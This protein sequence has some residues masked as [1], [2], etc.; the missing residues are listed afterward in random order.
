MYR[1]R[2]IL[3]FSLAAAA[4][5]FVPFSSCAQDEPPPETNA[6][7]KPAGY[8]FPSLGS[9]SSQG[10]LLPDS[11]PLTGM[12]NATIGIPEIRHSYWA[13]GLQFSSNISS[14][15]YG[16]STSSWNATNYFIGTMSL[17]EA[18]ERGTLAVNYSGGGF[19]SSDPQQG[20][21]W[22]Q[23]LALAQSYQT[24]RW[25]LQAFDQF[26]YI[27]QS[28]FG[29]GGGTSL[30]IPGTYGPGS[31]TIPGLGGNYTNGQSV[32]GVGAYYN[33]TF[34]LQATY[35]L[36]PRA[37]LTASASYGIL[38]F[39]QSGNFNSNTFVSSLGYNYTLTRK[40]TLG[41]V[42]RFSSYQFPGNPQAYGTSA[43]NVA[44]GRK[45]TGHLALSFFVGPEFTNYR[46]AFA[47]SSS[48]TGLSIYSNLIY[49]LPKGQL[50]AGY[51]HGLSAG[52]GVFIGS[53]LDQINA[54]YSRNLGRVWSG[55]LN[56]G[57]ARN[58][59]VGGTTFTGYPNTS[60]WFMGGN[61]GRP[62]GP[63][64]NFGLAY[65]ANISNYSTSGCT[66]ATCTGNFTYHI[67]TVSLQWHPRP[68][69]LP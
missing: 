14:N 48:S 1:F 34:G 39:V 22:Y 69:V 42:Y 57:Y 30:G 9:D 41:L 27:P 4:L 15:G 45:V 26:A 24:R 20:N 53:T 5:L 68:F 6:P 64:F 61:L 38:D 54:T 28:E 10:Q 3:C 31:T 51:T 46:V 40:D 67:V 16:Q 2:A 58:A 62:I 29:F 44:Y 33:N 50:S 17:L 43:F 21:G 56:F 60:S 37:S 65:T 36:T 35:A 7:P 47:G 25:L 32:Y 11:S 63:F 23:Q 12:Q 49:A 13:P 18:W 66:G 52:S 59:P 8:S 19:V 55:G